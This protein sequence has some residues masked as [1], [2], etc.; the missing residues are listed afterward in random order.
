ME[1]L[2][3][4]PPPPLPVNLAAPCPC[5]VFAYLL[6]SA[7]TRPVYEHQSVL[8]ISCV[9]TLVVNTPQLVHFPA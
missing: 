1:I 4:P 5:F 6:L 7:V 9:H 2:P 3:C 8:C